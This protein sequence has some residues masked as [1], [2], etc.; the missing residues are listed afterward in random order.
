[1]ANKFYQVKKTINGTEYKAQFSGISTSLR[2][3]DETYIEGTNTTSM[4]KMA[5]FLFEHIIVEPKGLT[6]DDF[7]SMEEF[8]AV[9][10]FAS[11]VMKG[12]FRKEALADAAEKAGEK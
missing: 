1:M 5:A 8:N 9:V 7:E 10:K 2:A 3:V 12:E 11:G 4:E 6:V